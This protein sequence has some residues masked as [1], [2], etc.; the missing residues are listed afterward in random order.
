MKIFD[1]DREAFDF[2]YIFISFIINAFTN[3]ENVRF[4]KKTALV[5]DYIDIYYFLKIYST[6]L[7][8]QLICFLIQYYELENIY[9]IVLDNLQKLYPEENFEELIFCLL[10]DIYVNYPIEWNS[11]FVKR[12]VDPKPRQLR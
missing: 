5:R 1:Y 6:E 2:N 7:N 4:S 10:D 11:N 8:F 12:V 3:T 9:C